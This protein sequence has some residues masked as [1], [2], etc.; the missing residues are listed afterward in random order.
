MFKPHSTRSA[1][2]SKAVVKGV[3]LADIIKTAG[4]SNAETFSKYYNK[5]VLPN[6]N[7]IQDSLLH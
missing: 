5:T 6:V 3:P 2:T 7:K 4:W 1:S